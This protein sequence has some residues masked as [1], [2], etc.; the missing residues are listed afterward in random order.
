MQFFLFIIAIIIPGL[1]FSSLPEIYAEE[2]PLDIVNAGIKYYDSKIKTVRFDGIFDNV[3][4]NT[5]GRTEYTSHTKIIKNFST[6]IAP[7]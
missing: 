1:F 3:L 2:I 6:N 7:K 4:N 5:K